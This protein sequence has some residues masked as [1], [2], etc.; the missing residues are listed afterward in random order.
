[1]GTWA[2]RV[3]L[4]TTE[5]RRTSTSLMVVDNV[6]VEGGGSQHFIRLFNSRHEREFVDSQSYHDIQWKNADLTVANRQQDYYWH[7]YRFDARKIVIVNVVDEGNRVNGNYL[8]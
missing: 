3:L 1:M 7:L 4:Y 6:P 5:I 2:S 8:A